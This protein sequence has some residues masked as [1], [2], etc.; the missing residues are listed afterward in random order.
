MWFL[1]VVLTAIGLTF[2]TGDAGSTGGPVF[3]RGATVTSPTPLTSE[4]HKN[5]V[6]HNAAFSTVLEPVSSSSSITQAGDPGLEVDSTKEDQGP[7]VSA[8]TSTHR[9]FSFKDVSYFV[10]VDGS[11]KQLLDQVNGYVKPGQLTALMGASGA[12]KT[13]LLDTISQRKT[14]GRVEGQMLMDGK[15]LGGTFSRSCGFCMQQDVHEPM[16]TVREALEF[17]AK[18]R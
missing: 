6:E 14:T 7:Q 4:K 2:M 17:S 1:Y 8:E 12:G 11:E 16:S 13:T 5:D 10:N 9:T 3:K 15:P 18:L